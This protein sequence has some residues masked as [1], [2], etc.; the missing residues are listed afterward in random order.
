MLLPR[1]DF[2]GLLVV[3][4]LVVRFRS[5]LLSRLLADLDKGWTADDWR[6][7]TRGRSF[8]RWDGSIRRLLQA[9]DRRAKLWIRFDGLFFGRW[10]AVGDI[11]LD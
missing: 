11:A 1:S 4:R 3:G 5:D 6:T 2:V 10:L 9:P 7:R 8:R